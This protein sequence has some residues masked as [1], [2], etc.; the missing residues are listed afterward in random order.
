MRLQ[1]K[2]LIGQRLYGNGAFYRVMN[3]GRTGSYS[4]AVEILRNWE[5]RGRLLLDIR[6]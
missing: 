1:L 6:N 4:E 3:E 5:S 2:A